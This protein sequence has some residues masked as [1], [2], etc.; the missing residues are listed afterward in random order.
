M[1]QIEVIGSNKIKLKKV[2]DDDRKLEKTWWGFKQP[3]S[4]YRTR[5]QGGDCAFGG[6]EGNA[7]SCKVYN[8]LATHFHIGNNRQTMREI[9][10]CM[11][12]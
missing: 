4:Y 12:K 3:N 10:K 6:T 9:P 7:D 11:Q 1:E 2:D 8:L 5:K